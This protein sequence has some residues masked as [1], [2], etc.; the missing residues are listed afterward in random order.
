MQLSPH[1]VEVKEVK[2]CTLQ[3]LYTQK[4]KGEEKE[5]KSLLS[6]F[7]ILT[8][9]TM[10]MLLFLAIFYSAGICMISSVTDP[11]DGMFLHDLLFYVNWKI[12]ILHTYMPKSSL[13]GSLIDF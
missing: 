12:N 5:T 9:A 13:K 4:K 1:S 2:G 10:R 8:M 3:L 11:N 7:D 6:A